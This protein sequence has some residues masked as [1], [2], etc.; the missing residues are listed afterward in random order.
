MDIFIHSA[1]PLG[2]WFPHHGERPML[3]MLAKG[4]RHECRLSARRGCTANGPVSAD[5][6][7]FSRVYTMRPMVI[8]TATDWLSV[9]VPRQRRTINR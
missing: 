3:L 4:C 8:A 5:Y 1:G 7:A 6:Q 9:V 2:G